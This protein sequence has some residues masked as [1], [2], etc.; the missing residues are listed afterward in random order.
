MDS[1]VAKDTLARSS[2]PVNYGQSQAAEF[3]E[4]KSGPPNRI[5]GIPDYQHRPVHPASSDRIYNYDAKYP[6]DPAGEEASENA[7]VWAIYLDEADVYDDDMICGF[8]DTTDALLVFAALFSAV[9]TTFLVET[10][11]ALLPDH[12]QI[13]T[14]L[15]TEQIQLLR[16]NGNSSII[17]GVPSSPY[18]AG[19]PT[20]SRFDIVVNILL[21]ASLSLSLSTA[22]FSVLIKQ[23]LQAY[24][25]KLS[26]TAKERALIRN[27]RFTG[28]EN[29]K[30]PEIIAILPLI[31]HT[32]L[33][34]FAAGLV[35]FAWTRN[36]AVS[37]VGDRHFHGDSI[38]I[39][40]FT[41][42]AP[43]VPGLPLPSSI[44]GRPTTIC[45]VAPGSLLHLCSS[46]RSGHCPTGQ[47]VRPYR[48]NSLRQEYCRVQ[49][50]PPL[51]LIHVEL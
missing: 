20:H 23:W 13:T 8:R 49:K 28:L 18:V 1:S 9:V 39:Y 22:L 41:G 45:P 21:F 35:V 33:W 40:R 5:L 44:A 6:P 15:L 14:Y 4:P 30:L 17:A 36:H 27:F 50:F 43:T 47:R 26:G 42:S 38:F 29:W 31:L 24:T 2:V 25:A 48:K 11:S 3:S 37:A 10:S 12:A 32:S 34:I 7:R 46:S 16:A 51:P 19:S